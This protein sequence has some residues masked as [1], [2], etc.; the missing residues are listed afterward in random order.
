MTQ[1]NPSPAFGPLLRVAALDKSRARDIEVVLDTPTAKAVAEALGILDARKIRLTGALEPI[2]SRDWRFVGKVGA[3]VVQ[4]CVVTLEPVTT[5]I[6]ADIDRSW[7]AGLEMPTADES[8][9]PV[10]V[11]LDPLGDEI[12]MGAVLVEAI[13]LALP[14]YPRADG[15]ETGELVFTEPGKEAMTDEDTKPFAGL[16]ALRDQLSQKDKE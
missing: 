13:A 5:R 6:E 4:P 14:D 10:D 15:A 3:T 1:T 11:T 8:E 9:T 2:G 16:A 7:V 12:D